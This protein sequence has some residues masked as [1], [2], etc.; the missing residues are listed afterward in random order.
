MV[1]NQ[2]NSCCHMGCPPMF[3]NLH[4]HRGYSLG[5]QKSKPLII[6]GI[7]SLG[8]E[9]RR[10][11]G[12]E[13]QYPTREPEALRC[14]GPFFMALAAFVPGTTRLLSAQTIGMHPALHPRL[15][16]RGLDDH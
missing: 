16:A 3:V 12:R 2:R 5:P 15:T 6:Y 8:G 9:H 7:V 4:F 1:K 13:D 14:W 11:E 10:R